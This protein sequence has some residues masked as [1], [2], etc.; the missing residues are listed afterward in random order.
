MLNISKMALQGKYTRT[1][2]GVASIFVVMTLMTLLALISLGFSTLMNRE[3]R[4][5]LDRQLSTAAQYAAESGVNDAR[6]YL[7]DP[8][9]GTAINGCETPPTPAAN[10]DFVQ[11]G[12][13]S[14]DG[15]FKY[16]CVI[17][18][19]TPKELI[20]E[21]AA[22]HT[23]VIKLS[24]VTLGSLS[25][26]YFGWQNN[27]VYQDDPS[28]LGGYGNLPQ[29]GA[30]TQDMTGLLKVG[31]VPMVGD[32]NDTDS[33]HGP[34][35][36]K[37]FYAKAL[38]TNTADAITQ[39]ASRTYYMYP[40]AGS[41]ALPS[42]GYGSLSASDGCVRYN[43]AN[44]DGG[45]VPGNCLN[46]IRK[47]ETTYKNQANPSYCQTV[48]ANLL[49][50]VN[51]GGPG[52]ANA[53]YLR[54]TAVYKPLRI[55]IQ[56]TDNSPLP[57]TLAISNA[58]GVIDITGTANDIVR[59]V[60]VRAPLQDDGYQL[61]F[62]L[63]SME[64]ICKLFR[65]DV[66]QPGIYDNPHLDLDAGPYN[67]D[68]NQSNC[69][70]PR[71]SNNIDN[72]GSPG[73]ALTA[74]PSVHISASP[75]NVNSGGSTTL[76]WNSTDADDGCTGT[77]FSTGAGDTRNGTAVGGPL[78]ANTTFTV[79]CTGPSGTASDHVDV[80][81]N[82]ALCTDTGASNFGQPLPCT[83]PPPDCASDRSVSGDAQGY[84]AHAV[85]GVA[86]CNT[87]APNGTW[88][89]IHGGANDVSGDFFG[90]MAPPGPYGVYCLD[91]G[92]GEWF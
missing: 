50:V 58:E 74:P 92:N 18:N 30:V 80:S 29:H 87:D 32:C 24:G 61:D 70:W 33:R 73:L 48:V 36:R 27:S 57:K 71:G 56:A 4:Q 89:N 90:Q 15:T 21:V 25:K 69:E 46:P 77:N 5:S 86:Q 11:G 6:R 76:T 62:G 10:L 68:A 34:G 83:Y 41:G 75:P 53:Y 45:T 91:Y 47:A 14:G 8:L 26:L 39:C 84:T 85:C 2:S 72:G 40:S 60:Q 42:C 43:T 23:K 19:P 1:E 16:T 63:Q 79:T 13:I 64:S 12:D 65:N 55:F 88:N 28:P 78:S 20:Y 7:E 3:V 17:V 31:I 59:R 66:P 37:D 9:G 67:T 81:V 49:P 82:P 52:T 22:G 51:F 38:T 54:L 35:S 44:D